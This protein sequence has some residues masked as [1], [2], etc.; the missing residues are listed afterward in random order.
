MTGPACARTDSEPRSA[1]AAAVAPLRGA[2]PA[3]A[4]AN[5]PCAATVLLEDRLSDHIT[6]AWTTGRSALLT[7]SR[8]G[9]S[10]RKLRERLKGEL[11]VAFH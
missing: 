7:P 8:P 11:V 2:R 5:E 10:G 6:T 3:T 1:P 4:P 9:N